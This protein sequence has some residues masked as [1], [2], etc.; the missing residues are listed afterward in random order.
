M[1]HVDELIAAHALHA[2]DPDDER[3]VASHVADCPECRAKLRDMDA[4]AGALAYAAPRVTP[5]P[6]LRTRVMAAVRPVTPAAEPAAAAPPL[7]AR[8]RT[9]WWPRLALVATPALA[10]AVLALGIWNLSLRDQ[11]ANTRHDFAAGVSVNL[12]G[13]GNAVANPLRLGHPVHQ[14]A[15]HPGRQ[16]LR[17]V[18]HLGLDRPPGRP[19]RRRQRTFD[20]DPA[21]QPWRHHRGHRGA[22][23]RPSAADL[24]AGRQRTPGEYLS[25]SP[26][27]Q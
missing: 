7:R 23:R 14:R 13:I 25:L 8:R 16:D 6:E 18:G 2:L 24:H 19:V 26:R 20:T 9:G 10:A 5:P 3:R 22:G 12:P 11:L 17:G 21:R 27:G 1:E 15:R 4:V